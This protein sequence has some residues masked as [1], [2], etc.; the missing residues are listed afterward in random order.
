MDAFENE[1]RTN[2]QMARKELRDVGSWTQFLRLPGFRLVIRSS[3]AYL[4]VPAFFWVWRGPPGYRHGARR[5]GTATLLREIKIS[6]W[7]VGR[8]GG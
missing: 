4:V 1:E 3:N 6:G 8:C 5:S 7:L 2:S